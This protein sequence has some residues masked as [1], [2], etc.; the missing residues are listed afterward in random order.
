MSLII[1]IVKVCVCVH[2]S[3]VM[4]LTI[5]LI[6]DGSKLTPGIATFLLTPNFLK[7]IKYL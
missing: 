3:H 4:V 2:I 7:Q 6:S 1:S 5:Y